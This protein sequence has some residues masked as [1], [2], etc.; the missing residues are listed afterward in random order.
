MS[1]VTDKHMYNIH[2]NTGNAY[3]DNFSFSNI[4][5]YQ[6]KAPNFVED[7]KKEKVRDPEWGQSGDNT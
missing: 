2:A 5:L 1:E 6:R 3:Q 7:E 4:E